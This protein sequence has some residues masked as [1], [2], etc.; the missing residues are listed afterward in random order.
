MEFVS[1][2][3]SSRKPNGEIDFNALAQILERNLNESLPDFDLVESLFGEINHAVVRSLKSKKKIRFLQQYQEWLLDIID[4]MVT[5]GEVKKLSTEFIRDMRPQLTKLKTADP[6]DVLETFEHRS[7]CE[8]IVTK[9]C[10]PWKVPTWLEK[11][12]VSQFRFFFWRLDEKRET[13]YN[14]IMEK[15]WCRL[16]RNC[17]IDTTWSLPLWKQHL[18]FT[19][20]VCS[21]SCLEILR[22]K[23]PCFNIP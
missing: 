20:Q 22:Q 17:L 7:R 15:T 23:D 19:H 2:K 12:V 21:Y 3:L 18:H 10:L 11:T 16:C 9:F 13:L 5:Y 4:M 1:V 6:E 8:D 14:A